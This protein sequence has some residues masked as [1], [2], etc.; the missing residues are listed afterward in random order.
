MTPQEFTAARQNF[1]MARKEFGVLL[2]YTGDLRNV[3][4]TV[5]R[6]ELGPDVHGGRA[7]PPTIERLVRLLVW[8]KDDYGY[9]PDLDNGR[10]EP[11]EM[12]EVF[13][14]GDA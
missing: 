11:M 1:G 8:F 10:R 2:G 14:N 9:L 13:Q 12:P 3:Y 7:I 6:Y 4:M 5:K